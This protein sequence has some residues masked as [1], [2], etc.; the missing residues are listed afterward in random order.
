MPATESR[1]LLTLM[2]I[3]EFI[4]RQKIVAVCCLNYSF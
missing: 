1:G 2:A 4:N 3:N